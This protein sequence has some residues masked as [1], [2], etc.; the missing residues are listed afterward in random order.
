LD[1]DVGVFED[2]ALGGV[3]VEAVG[4]EEEGFGGGLAVGVVAGADEGV[5]E[6]EDVEGFEGF[7]DGLAGAAG[8]NG[9][10]E[11]AVVGVDDFEDFGDGFEIVDEGVVEVFLAGGEGFDRDV[12]VVAAVDGFDDSG[13][14]DTA[15][16]VEE[17]FGEVGAA[18]LGEGLGPGDEV[19]GHGVDDGAVAVEEEGGEGAGGEL[20]MHGIKSKR[21]GL[22]NVWAAYEKAY[23]GG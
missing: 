13:D 11:L 16:P 12:E 23:P 7:D 20:K 6:V 4:G 5:E 14:G 17:F 21:R 19:E 10:G 22:W 15:H 9:E 3:Y 2:E 8:D 1:A 18:V